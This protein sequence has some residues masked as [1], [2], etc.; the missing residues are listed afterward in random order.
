[1]EDVKQLWDLR[2]SPEEN[3]QQQWKFDPPEPTFDTERGASRSSR[4]VNGKNCFASA[5]VAAFCMCHRYDWLMG[6]Q[7]SRD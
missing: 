2:P 6:C 1:M 5:D 7:Y 4:P 3:R